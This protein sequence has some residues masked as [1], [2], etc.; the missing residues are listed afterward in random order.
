MVP[1]SSVLRLWKIHYLSLSSTTLQLKCFDYASCMRACYVAFVVSHILQ[2]CGPQ[3][4]RLL[5]LSMRLS[6]QEYQSVLPC[7][8][9]WDL[10]NPGTEPVFLIPPALA[11]GFFTTR[12]ILEAPMLLEALIN[13]L[14]LHFLPTIWKKN[15]LL[16][17][18]FFF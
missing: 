14:S 8:P 18:Q 11:G 12:A 2:W 17:A 9:P 16:Q 6:R 4:A 5:S 3:T 7:P 1:K 13:F 10:P 15:N